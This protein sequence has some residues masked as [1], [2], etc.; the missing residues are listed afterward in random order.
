M[1]SNLNQVEI[2]DLIIRTVINLIHVRVVYCTQLHIKCIE[3][4]ISLI[5]EIKPNI[6]LKTHLCPT[7]V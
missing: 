4:I 7:K 3:I 6:Q 2:S 1:L 5:E